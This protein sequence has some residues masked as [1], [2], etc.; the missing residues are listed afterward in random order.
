[1]LMGSRFVF[2]FA[3]ILLSLIVTRFCFRT[4][5]GQESQDPILS[6]LLTARV[7]IV[8]ANCEMA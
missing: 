5:C 2:F 6:F 1:M 4:C 3:P 7:K 8:A